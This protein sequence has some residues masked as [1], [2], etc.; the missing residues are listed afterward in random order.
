MS[1][2]VITVEGPSRSV[3]QKKKLVEMLTSALKEAY[4][5]PEDFEHIIVIIN[6]NKPENIGSNGILLS[7]MKKR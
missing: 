1:M 3:E 5:Y 6:E 4:G 7:E 2:P